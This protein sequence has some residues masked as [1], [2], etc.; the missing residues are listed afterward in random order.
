MS[1]KLGWNAIFMLETRLICSNAMSDSTARDMSP[2]YTW[3][4]YYNS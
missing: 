2:L 1:L 3:A 4:Y